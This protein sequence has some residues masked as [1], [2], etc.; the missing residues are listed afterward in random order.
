M[1]DIGPN[2]VLARRRLEVHRSELKLSLDRMD[3]RRLE[4]DDEL[5]K[6]QENMNA[7]QKAIQAIDDELQKLSK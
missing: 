4:M 3:L 7:T 2:I 6:I 1:A 5:K